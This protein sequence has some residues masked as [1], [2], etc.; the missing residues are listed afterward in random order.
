[1][2]WALFLSVPAAFGLQP[3]CLR[4]V[5]QAKARNRGDIIRGLY[6]WGSSVPLLFGALLAF[7]FFLVM[8]VAADGV[9]PELRDSLLV[10]G[11]MIP[12]LALGRAQTGFL[13]G[14]SMPIWAQLPETLLKPLLLGVLAGVLS[15]MYEEL[16]PIPAIAAMFVISVAVAGLQRARLSREIARLID[17]ATASYEVRAWLRVAVPLMGVGIFQAILE[18]T[19]V[20]LMGAFADPEELGIYQAASRVALLLGVVAISVNAAASS[21]LVVA[22]NDAHPGPLRSLLST[23]LPLIFLPTIALAGITIYFGEFIL[24]QFGTDFSAGYLALIILAAGQVVSAAAGPIILLMNVTGMQTEAF[25]ILGIS[26]AFNVVCGLILVP[27]FQ[28]IGAAVSTAM[29]LALWNLW[30]VAKFREKRG[31]TCLVFFSGRTAR[32]R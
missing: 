21:R 7:G 1:M 26:A 4:S 3:T 31:I 5:A 2:T 14:F 12:I 17:S 6:L 11:A 10:G 18:R 30:A 15:I 28:G 29:S 23:V 32:P 20:L 9:R 19:D 24:R 13:L 25:R 22:G 16:T 8:H 27:S